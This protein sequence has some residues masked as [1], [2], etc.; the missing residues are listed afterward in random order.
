MNSPTRQ[1][2]RSFV[3]FVL[4]MVLGASLGILIISLDR[5]VLRWQIAIV[6]GIVATFAALV[7]NNRDKVFRIVLALFALSIPINLHTSIFDRPHIG[8][9]SV[10]IS[11]SII[12]VFILFLLMMHKRVI[13]GKTYFDFNK[14]LILPVL[15][16]TLAGILSLQ[17]AEHPELVGLEILRILTLL[18]IML[19]IMNLKNEK[20]IRLFVL[21][22]LIGFLME[23]IIAFTQ[24]WTDKP[25]GLA[26][27]GEGEL[28]TQDVGYT[29]SRAGGTIGHPNILA[30]YLEILLPLIFSLMLVERNFRIRLYLMGTL[31]IGLVALVATLSRAGWVT[32]PISFCIVLLVLFKGH[33]FRLSTFVKLFLLSCLFLPI[34][35]VASPVIEKRLTYDDYESASN[36]IPLNEAT[37]SII[38][39]FPV[40]GA[41]LNNFPEF[42]HKYDK[43]GKSSILQE[44]HVVHN[45]FLWVWAET[46][47]IGL[48]AFFWMF[49]SV[50]VV[51]TALLSKVDLWHR[52]LLTGIGAGLFAHLLHGLVDPGFRINLPT[53]VLVYTLIGL[54]GAVS[55]QYRRKNSL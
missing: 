48:L 47:T 44:R 38:K 33:F 22:L 5:L 55:I 15:A 31:G 27:F 26:R 4:C 53:S 32:I 10:A 19:V 28:I 40:V 30:Y 39:R 7:I 3:S 51:I 43:T 29:I 13:T 45:L 18:G 46:G 54:V 36:R 14:M 9:S 52:A 2:K 21:F 6:L 1:T 23:G 24:Y 8:T 16:Y 12:L 20:Q 50:F 11:V 34:L 17:N 42:F 49:G 41:G 35:Y 25:L 37:L